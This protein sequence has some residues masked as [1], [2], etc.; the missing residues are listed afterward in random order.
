MSVRT[1]ARHDPRHARRPATIFVGRARGSYYT[2]SQMHEGMRLRTSLLCGVTATLLALALYAAAAPS[3]FAHAAFLESSPEAGVRLERA[4]KQV[5]L[6][7]TE[8]L[9]RSLSKVELVDLDDGRPIDAAMS[10][11]SERQVVLRPSTRLETAAYELRWHTVS[12]RDGHALEGTYSFGLRTAATGR[13]HQTEES[14]LAR[15]GWL[16]VGL[17]GGFYVTLFFFAGGVLNAALLSGRGAP[18]GWLVPPPVAELVRRAGADPEALI[19]RLW[20]TTVDAGWLAAGAAA[21][22]AV[23]EAADAG[24]GLSPSGLASFLLSNAAGLARVG[25]VALLVLAV[26]L[27]GRFRRAAAAV[28]VLALLTIAVGGHANSAEPRVAAVGSDLIHL[29]AGALW[30]GGIAQIAASW[31][32]LRRSAS[33]GLGLG[34]MRAVLRRFG[35]VALPAFVFVIWSGV[36]NALIELGEARALWETGYG[37]VLTVKLALVALIG[38]AS[39]WHAFRLRPRLLA[40][41]PH[42]P[43]RLERRHWRLVRSEPVLGAGVVVAAAL[44]VA[45]PLPPRQF[46]E[47]AG[48]DEALAAAPACDPCPQRK[49]RAD[50]LSVAEQAG[51]SIAAVWLR[52][53][54]EGWRGEL[55]LLDANAKPLE[56]AVRTPGAELRGCGAGCW[57]LSLA[58]DPRTLAVRVSEGGETYTARL[59]TRWQPDGE[60]SARRLLER[61]QETMRRLRSL[62][63]HERVTSGPGSHAE[64]G[65]RFQAPKRMAYD[66]GRYESVAIGARQWSRVDG[67]PWEAGRSGGGLPFRTRTWFRWTPYAQS[68]RLLESRRRG[69]RPIAEI[70]LMEPGTPVWL[71]LEID[72]RTARVLHVRMVT[73]GHFMD[74]RFYAFNR[75]VTIQPPVGRP[76][77]R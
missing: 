68:V 32:P 34:V 70:A 64:T 71:R 40:A 27:S 47:A 44:L 1:Y 38:A 23:A 52:R 48:V 77:E 8:P 10:P 14:P 3:A 55:Q 6:S 66:T 74:Q 18:A 20:R 43:P 33:Q 21:A 63:E 58:S 7:F 31:L 9:D 72:R 30:I 24:G 35:K 49:P 5:T 76:R 53:E 11:G 26:A 29:V 50:E 19:V 57:R 25:T 67:L 2:A 41:N 60:A 56:A 28:I 73:G 75:P 69:G 12:T 54:G 22:T 65:Y 37:R 17:R 42:P 36:L 13:A 61:A 45:F 62:R 4:P 39:C 51:S 15:A 59:P 16:R 46:R